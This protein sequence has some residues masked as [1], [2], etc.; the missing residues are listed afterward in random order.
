L[1]TSS[2]PDLLPPEDPFSSYSYFVN[3]RCKIAASGFCIVLLNIWFKIFIF[4][5]LGLTLTVM[6]FLSSGDVIEVATVLIV[7]LLALVQFSFGGSG[8]CVLFL[9]VG[10]CF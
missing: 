4:F 2:C 1:F 7:I 3:A 6:V 9:I 10:E 8:F 5:L